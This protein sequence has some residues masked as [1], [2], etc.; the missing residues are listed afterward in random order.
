MEGIEQDPKMK[1]GGVLYVQ[2]TRV[3]V[4]TKVYFEK[5]KKEYVLLYLLE[6]LQRENKGPYPVHEAPANAGSGDGNF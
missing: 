5:K 2:Q 6:K 3:H 1:V 4:S